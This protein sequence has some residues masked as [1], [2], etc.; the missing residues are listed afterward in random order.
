[1]L[2][3]RNQLSAEPAAREGNCPE[4]RR[5]RNQPV[6]PFLRKKRSQRQ[7]EIPLSIAMVPNETY[8]MKIFVSNIFGADL[9]IY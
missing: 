7:A 8:A 6:G 2:S 9:S 3:T 4:E 5:A 1:M